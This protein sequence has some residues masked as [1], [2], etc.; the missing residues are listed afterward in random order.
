M[1]IYNEQLTRKLIESEIDLT[2][3][4]V[5]PKAVF[6]AHH[7][8]IEAVEEVSHIETITRPSGK[9]V[10]KKIIDVPAV[11]GKDAWDEYEFVLVYRPFTEK[12]LAKKEIATLKKKLADT[13]YQA[14][15]YAEGLINEYD[16]AEIKRQRQEWRDE[17]NRLEMIAKTF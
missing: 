8:A 16:Y 10:E 9:L 13:D 17:I 2:K 7:D 11:K 14:I 1:A 15:K 12:Q 3:G 4:R 6:V 5:A